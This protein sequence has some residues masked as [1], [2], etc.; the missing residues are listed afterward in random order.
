MVILQLSFPLGFRMLGSNQTPHLG[1]DGQGFRKTEHYCQAQ[2]SPFKIHP[3]W[4]WQSF[5]NSRG[6]ITHDPGELLLF[7]VSYLHLPS[8]IS[9]NTGVICLFCISHELSAMR[10]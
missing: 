3:C 4:Q 10:T 2:I 1:V 6:T 5:L 9:R 7:R 8:E